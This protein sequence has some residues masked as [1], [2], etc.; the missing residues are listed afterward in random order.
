MKEQFKIEAHDSEVLCLEYSTND[1]PYNM[2]ASASRD[3][4]IHVFDTKNVS[5]LFN[6]LN[7]LIVI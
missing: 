2:L 5:S 3:R 1:S 7:S 6:F 4:L